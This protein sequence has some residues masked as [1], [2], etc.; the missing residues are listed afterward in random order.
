MYTSYIMMS[1]LKTVLLHIY[2]QSVPVVINYLTPGAIVRDYHES[3]DVASTPAVTTHGSFTA[4]I[5]ERILA[6]SRAREVERRGSSTETTITYAV[7][8]AGASG[9]GGGGG[10]EESAKQQAFIELQQMAETTATPTKSPKRPVTKQ[11]G[12]DQ[13]AVTAFVALSLVSLVSFWL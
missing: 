12:K 5:R 6:Q 10:A 8:K 9:D 2:Q 4:Q 13:A 7:E 1:S 11:A 3:G